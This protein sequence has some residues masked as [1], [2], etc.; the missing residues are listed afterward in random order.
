MSLTLARVEFRHSR[1][2][3]CDS[4]SRNSEFLK[5]SFRTH[6]G[7]I[8][9]LVL[10][11][12]LK[13]APLFL[14]GQF[15]GEDSFYFY[16]TAYNQPWYLA[17]TTPYAGYLHVLPM[18]LAELLWNLP[19]SIL[20]W[21]NH[22]VALFLCVGALSWFYTP[23]CR[24]LIESDNVRA[25][26][27]CFLALMPFQP[28]LGML[29]GLHWYVAFTVG[30]I[31]L[32]ELPRRHF[33]TI[34]ISVFAVLSAWS[35]PSTIVLIPIAVI[36][37]WLLRSDRRRILPMS[38]LIASLSYLLAILW[39]F[40]PMSSQSHYADYLVAAQATWQMFHEGLFLRAIV[41]LGFAD[42]IPSIVK[43]VLQVTAFFALIWFSWRQR[44]SPRI[45]LGLCM[46]VVSLMILILTM[47]R[48]HQSALVLKTDLLLIER[49]LTTPAF[50]FMTGVAVLLAPYMKHIS[51]YL[52]VILYSVCLLF[53]FWGA[54]PLSGKYPLDLAF[55]HRDKVKALKKYDK[56]YLSGEIEGET[57][58]M[59]GWTPYQAM[60]L[61][62]GGGRYCENPDSLSC[63]FGKKLTVLTEGKYEVDWFG[64]FDVVDRNWLNHEELGRIKMLGYSR[65]FYWY[66]DK[67]GQRYVTGPAIY[68]N[69]LTFPPKGMFRLGDL[70]DISDAQN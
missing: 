27:V 9:L 38:F 5:Y 51:R 65:G 35:S 64:T 48:G 3:Q 49:Y 60:R 31:L 59:P 39:L 26:V 36:R 1:L 17:V 54:T 25:G 41:G 61:R 43:A 37:W 10:V 66:M 63:I 40:K 4:Q 12:F 20:P 33:G 44:Q 62:I 42:F 14:A 13:N 18:L 16:E 70:I 57:L 69:C 67:L 68:P 2:M 50:Y 8:A 32:G 6:L 22:I 11:L 45:W 56:M 47:F 52:L 53:L 34:S 15:V 28:N 24:S 29:L 58:A 46:I 7:L 21:S 55:P 23:F 19:F 30:L